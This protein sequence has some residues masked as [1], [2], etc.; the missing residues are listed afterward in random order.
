[1]YADSSFMSEVGECILYA[2]SSFISEFKAPQVLAE[3]ALDTQ[4]RLD[5]TS[6][7]FV[8]FQT[9]VHTHFETCSVF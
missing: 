1:M 2:Y 8:S 5:H 3:R 4:V 9:V 7:T 6:R